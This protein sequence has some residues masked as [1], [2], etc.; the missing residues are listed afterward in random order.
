MRKTVSVTCLA[1]GFFLLILCAAFTVVQ[2][3][4]AE[5]AWFEQEF[6]KLSLAEDMGMTLGDLGA[7]VR[8]LVNYLNGQ[9]E[10]IDVLVTVN[11]QQVR[12]F[13]LD[14]EIV[15][16]REVKDL[17]QW[18][19]GARNVGM[20]LAAVLCLI[21]VVLDGKDALRNV[22]WGYFW[23]LG[24]FLVL[25]AFAGTWAAINFDSFWTAF[26]KVVF[27]DSENWLLPMESRMIQM[28]PSELFRDLVMRMGGRMLLIFL[29][30]AAVAVLVLVIQQRRQ[31]AK[32]ALNMPQDRPKTPAE[33]LAAVQGPDMLAVHKR[34]NMTNM[35]VSERRKLLEE[36]ERQ[37]QA[38]ATP[39]E[40]DEADF[41]DAALDTPVES[42]KRIEFA[43]ADEAAQARSVEE[44][45][46]YDELL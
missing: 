38:L 9:T 21:G 26:H 23:A 18:F 14:I 22:C 15:H 12:M 6:T 37:R 7:S 44:D 36:Q 45:D 31:R 32:E 35:T 17:W 41:R 42:R 3:T 24:A 30:L 5:T 13:D 40:G 2:L 33:E 20:L 16:M 25:A 43:P 39:D 46:D 27:P 11:G 1:L 8:T 19:V 4:A 29:A 28:L 34:V 10:T